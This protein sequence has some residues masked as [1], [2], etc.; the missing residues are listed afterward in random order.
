[1]NWYGQASGGPG[2]KH[3][4]ATPLGA[5]S[6]HGMQYLYISLLYVNQSP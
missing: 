6:V 2:R 1:M 5:I 4:H 3:N